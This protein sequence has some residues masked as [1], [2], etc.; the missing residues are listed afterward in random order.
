MSKLKYG[1]LRGRVVAR[2]VRGRNN[3]PR[4]PDVL[5]Q[6]LRFTMIDCKRARSAG[7]TLT[8]IPLRMP[9]SRT[10]APREYSKR[11]R[12]R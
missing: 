2:A 8:I 9:D 4:P 10:S 6:L 11:A 5:L 7:V 1:A 12:R 3:D